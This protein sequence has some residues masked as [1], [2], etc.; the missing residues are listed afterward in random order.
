MTVTE[1]PL[2]PEFRTFGN[3][4]HHLVI[5]AHSTVYADS[6]VTD[7]YLVQTHNVGAIND[8]LTT[9]TTRTNTGF[10]TVIISGVSRSDTHFGGPTPFRFLH[11]GLVPT[12]KED[13]NG[14]ATL[15]TTFQPP[16]G[17]GGPETPATVSTTSETLAVAS[18]TEGS[19][20]PLTGNT[21]SQYHTAATGTAAT[22]DPVMISTTFQYLTAP[23]GTGVSMASVTDNTTSPTGTSSVSADDDVVIQTVIVYPV[24]SIAPETSSDNPLDHTHGGPPTPHD[25]VS[26]SL[27]PTSNE[28]APTQTIGI[29]TN[30]TESAP[31]PPQLAS[32]S[33]IKRFANDE[34]TPLERKDGVYSIPKA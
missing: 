31:S 24:K 8:E 32:L 15:T 25:P 27:F 20:A 13:L 2:L 14:L 18:G 6:A 33:A 26:A 1:D 12:E 19:K 7:I 17:T 21:I 5:A 30:V 29:L 4:A 3:V 22:S 23:T 28:I 9:T 11:S 16:N 10:E 34:S